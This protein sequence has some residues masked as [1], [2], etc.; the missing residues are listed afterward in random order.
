[1]Y[2]L[3]CNEIGWKFFRDEMFGDTASGTNAQKMQDFCNEFKLENPE[4]YADVE[5]VVKKVLGE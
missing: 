4:I 3:M 5:P 1:M 2:A